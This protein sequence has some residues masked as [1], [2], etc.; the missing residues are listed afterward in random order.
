MSSWSVLANQG[1]HLRAPLPETTA[2]AAGI[3]FM[4]LVCVA[5]GVYL[6]RRRHP[7]RPVTD[8]W[9]ALAVMGEL[10]PH[11]W[12]AQITLYGWGAPPPPDA[13][14]SRVPLVEVEW[15]RFAEDSEEVIVARRVW[16]PRI[17]EALQTMVDD[18]RTELALEEIEQS[19]AGGDE[20]SW[21][22]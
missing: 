7:A 20:A 19:S 13:P 18:R 21:N 2:L 15:K 12:Q 9:S 8:Q 1:G 4:A 14:P 10:C 16:T 17:S 6:H 5:I 22:G 11:G 3:V